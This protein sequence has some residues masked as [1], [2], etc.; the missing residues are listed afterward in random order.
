MAELLIG[1]LLLSEDLPEVGQVDRGALTTVEGI[2]VDM[3]NLLACILTA[4]P[5]C[6]SRPERMHSMSPVPQTTT[7]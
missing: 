7:S 5:S 3:E 4:V 6:E 1:L 2:A